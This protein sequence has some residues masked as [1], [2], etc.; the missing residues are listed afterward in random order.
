MQRQ[1]TQCSCIH[2]STSS[3]THVYYGYLI[4]MLITSQVVLAGGCSRIPSIRS[5]LSDVFYGK[6]L[7]S[8]IDADLAVA[9]GAAL[10]GA[11]L[12]GVSQGL[13]KVSASALMLAK[14]CTYVYRLYV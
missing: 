9:E 2:R 4:V 14:T 6:E 5:M 7:C 10:R 1:R 8:S 3:D 13:L 11:I 12:S